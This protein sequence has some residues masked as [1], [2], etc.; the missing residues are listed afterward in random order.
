[1]VST[2][3]WGEGTKFYFSGILLVTLVLIS[4][5]QS[6]AQEQGYDSE[7]LFIALFSNGDAA[8]EY[9]ISID[10]PLAEETIVTLFA[11]NTITNLI[12]VDDEDNVIEYDPG[13]VPNEIALRTPAVPNARISYSTP[14]LVDKTQG[15][16]IFSLDSISISHAVLLPSD[17]V[18]TDPGENYPAIKHFGDRQLLTFKPGDVRFVY[19]IGVLGTEEQANIVIRLAETTI[20]ETSEKYPEIVLS[21]ANGLLQNATIARDDE[22]FPDAEGLAGQANDAALATALDYEAAQVAISGTDGQI[23]QAAGEGRDTVEAVN[24]L[25]QARSEFTAGNYV[26]ARD[27]AEDA[28][29]L[30]G[31]RPAEPQMPLFVIVLAAVAA[32]GGVGALLYLRSRKP[33]PVVRQ[34][35]ADGRSAN[36]DAKAE[37]NTPIRELDEG[38]PEI[39]FMP[40]SLI[41]KAPDSQL[42]VSGALP[43]SQIDKSVLSSIVV[44][45]VEEKP[46]LR[47]ED[48]DVLRYLAE[49]EGAAFESE[50]RTKFQLPK[51]TIWRLVK[52]LE[53]EELIEIRKAGGQNLIKLKFENRQS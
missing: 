2:Q 12:V 4:G 45:I 44:K 23:R 50:I 20:R 40:G 34:Q 39:P 5:H 9:D 16:W 25:E 8:V 6:F 22:R 35:V 32:G 19:V 28:I 36:S 47:P 13:S 48:Q 17:S 52:R 3:S 1:M 37:I 43:E 26:Q 14:D 27:S 29:S 33:A 10:N 18:L 46:H 30:I 24:Q 51:T 49:K 53:R 7:S 21:L 41:E 31:S 38:A 42:G 15:N 11:Q